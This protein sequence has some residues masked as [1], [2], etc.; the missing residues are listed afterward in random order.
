MQLLNFI[1]HN[2][3]WK[4]ILKE[5]P[6][7]ITIKYKDNLAIFTYSQIDSDF[8][9]PIVRECRGLILDTQTMAPVCVPFNKFGNYGEGYVPFIDWTTARVQ[10]KVD[11]SLIKVWWYKDSWR[12]STNG[13]ID[14]QDA[15]IDSDIVPYKN[16][17]ELFCAGAESS[18]L[19]YEILDK[20]NTY[21]FELV[22][23]FNRVVVPYNEVK[24][25][26]IGTRNNKS[27]SEIDVDIGIEKPKTYGLRSFDEC[28]SATSRMPFSEEGY[29]VVD[30]D[31]N[32]VKIK[33]PAYVAAHH[34]KNNG[35]ITKAR[36]ITMLR[37][38]EEEEFLNYYPEYRP[39]FDEVE[40]MTD[41]FVEIMQN[42][43][44]GLECAVQKLTR[45]Q[46]AELAKQTVCP[47]LLFSWIDGRT[48]TAKEWLFS[49]T[50]EKIVYWISLDR[51]KI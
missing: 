41:R 20:E 8:Y 7:H 46:F 33:S 24:I 34:L 45:K 3:D 18:G 21:M 42:E 15:P 49:Q 30:G 12:V 31:W 27:L 48:T 1:K 37:A 32:R 14:A 19:I 47:P 51:N 22:S 2:P 26:H 11:G 39:M 28:I 25:Y 13:T 44:N 29:V 10:E 43:I 17:Y 16:F 9:N 38:N 4:N 35:V 23:P 5:S 40:K 36:I 6:Y 50:D